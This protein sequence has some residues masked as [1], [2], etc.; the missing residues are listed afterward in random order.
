MRDLHAEKASV[1]IC[2]LAYL[3]D[4]SFGKPQDA[5]PE[6]LGNPTP[7]ALTREQRAVVRQWLAENEESEEWIEL[8]MV[9][10]ISLQV[11]SGAEGEFVRTADTETWRALALELLENSD[12]HEF[13]ELRAK[14]RLA[15]FDVLGD[16]DESLKETSPLGRGRRSYPCVP[17]PALTPRTESP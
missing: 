12:R 3:M 13:S 17:L 8:Q 9:N 1:E 11:D 16:L 10:E 14:R 2:A 15:L 5:E 4:Q 6:D 7:R